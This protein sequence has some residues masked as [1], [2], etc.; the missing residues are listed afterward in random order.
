MIISEDIKARIYLK[1]AQFTIATSIAPRKHEVQ[2]AAVNSW[3]ECGFKVISVN[4][5]NEISALESIYPRVKFVDAPRDSS[6]ITGKPLIFVDD[7]L[8]ALK[9]SQSL[10]YGI[11]NSDIILRLSKWQ[12]KQLAR[13]ARGSLV[14]GSRVDIESTDLMEGEF[15]QEGFDFFFFDNVVANVIVPSEFCLG[16]PWWD[17]WF[18]LIPI[19][20]GIPIA[21]L[22]TPAAYHV[23]HEI[24]WDWQL[25]EAYCHKLLS[26]LISLDDIK[27]ID[28][29]LKHI[30]ASFEH[31]N[32]FNGID[33]EILSF[34]NGKSAAISYRNCTQCEKLRDLIANIVRKW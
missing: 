31:M 22:V 15:F 20:K 27:L 6:S 23:R 18:P 16:A 4:T 34:I 1:R 8:K 17:Y 3:F 21:R 10:L 19:L 5:S 14:F 30:V 12:L 28:N 24:V 2:L 29:S 26:L 32:S 33:Q 13:D 11:I 25:H 7:V 9:Q